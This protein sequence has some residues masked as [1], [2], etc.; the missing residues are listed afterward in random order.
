[1]STTSHESCRGPNR[2]WT[3]SFGA[4]KI[5]S[6]G[7]D[8]AASSAFLVSLKLRC[9]EVERNRP[10][11]EDGLRLNQLSSTNARAVIKAL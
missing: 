4:T 3:T 2:L 5:A 8:A 11:P 6:K 10:M 1:M 9:M 7:Q